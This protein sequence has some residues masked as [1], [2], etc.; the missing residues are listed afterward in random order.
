MFQEEWEKMK[1]NDWGKQKS[2]RETA[3]SGQRIQ[4]Y[5][6]TCPRLTRFDDDG[7]S[8]TCTDLG[9]RF[10]DSFVPAPFFFFFFFF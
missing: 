1:L 8:P 4:G 7:F 5:V 2:E 9:G 6:L 3:R 10:D